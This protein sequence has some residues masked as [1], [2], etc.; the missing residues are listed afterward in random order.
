MLNLALIYIIGFFYMLQYDLRCYHFNRFYNTQFV[1][2][3]ECKKK[4]Y[5]FIPAQLGFCGCCSDIDTDMG[6]SAG[7]ERQKERKGE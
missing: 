6:S 2:V 3:V 1:K 4:L 7:V 5:Y